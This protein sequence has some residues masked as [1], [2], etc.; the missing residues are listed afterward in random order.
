MFKVG[1]EVGWDAVKA[2]G[3]EGCAGRGGTS[4]C[5]I[6][7]MDHNGC[8]VSYDFLPRIDIRKVL[9]GTGVLT[10]K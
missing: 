10:A 9:Y 1:L 6:V 4:E 5:Q 7:Y 3:D 2:L 8:R